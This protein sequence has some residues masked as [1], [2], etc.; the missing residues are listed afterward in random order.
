MLSG[1][2]HYEPKGG[3]MSQTQYQAHWK[4]HGSIWSHWDAKT[5]DQSYQNGVADS[6]ETGRRYT[7]LFCMISYNHM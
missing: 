4:Y 2:D 7:G 1:Y 6:G 5:T 3:K